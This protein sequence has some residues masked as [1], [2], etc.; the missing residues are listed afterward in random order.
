MQQEFQSFDGR[1]V[2]RLEIDKYPDIC[3]ICFHKNVVNPRYYAYK[4]LDE[5]QIIFQCASEK[6]QSLFIGYY[7]RSFHNSDLTLV[8][9]KPKNIQKEIF[10]QKVQEC[11][12]EFVKIYNQAKTAEDFELDEIAGV[13]YRKALE[14][15]I[16]DYLIQIDAQKEDE[17]KKMFLGKCIQDNIDDPKIKACAERA[18]WLGNDETHYMRE[19]NDK[20]I[21]DLKTLIKMTTNWI[22]NS[23][24][25]EAY[26]KTMPDGK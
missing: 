23:L 13:G 22:E 5:A 16:K 1:S 10:P 20:D 25:T 21:N 7:K 8:S 9:L 17:I 15:L 24:L 4:N 26:L 2:R 6:C 11:S 18:A 19:W 14:F 12:K 3:P